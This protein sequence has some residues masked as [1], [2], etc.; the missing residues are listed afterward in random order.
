VSTVLVDNGPQLKR[1]HARAKGRGARIIKQTSHIT[2]TVSD[3]AKAK[4][5]ASP[6]KPTASAKGKN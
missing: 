5:K 4:A 6:A 1:M 3:E 2:V